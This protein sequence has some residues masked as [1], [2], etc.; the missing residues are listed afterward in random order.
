[1]PRVWP[2]PPR[3]LKAAVT[4]PWPL[5]SSAPPVIRP[6]VSGWAE[7][8][9]ERGSLG[10]VDVQRRHDVHVGV[11]VRRST[12]DVV[13]DHA[14]GAARGHVGALGHARVHAALAGH[15]LA[16]EAVRGGRHLAEVV[17]VAGCGGGQD[18]RCLAGLVAGRGDA[19]ESE[20]GPRRPEGGAALEALVRRRCGRGGDPRLAVVDRVRAGTGIPAGGGHE[21]TGR[22]G[23]EE[24]EGD[25][26]RIRILPAADREVD[27][28][29]P[30]HDGLLDG[31]RGVRRIAAGAI[32]PVG[33][34]EADLVGREVRAGGH[35]GD[36]GA[37]RR[38]HAAVAGRGGGRVGAVPVVVTGG[39]ELVEE[40][41]ARSA[42]GVEGRH[43][44]RGPDQLVVAGER[45]VVRV[46]GS[47]AELAGGAVPLRGRR[48]VAVVLDGGVLRPDPGVDDPDDHALAG[49]RL[50]ARLLPQGGSA[51][52][53]GAA[54]GLHG[55][56]DVR[57]DRLH[58]GKGVQLLDLVGRQHDGDAADDLAEA[59]HEPRA[60]QAGAH[61]ALELAFLVGEE[62]LV[63]AGPRGVRFD[64]A[65]SR[66]L[67]AGRFETRHVAHVFRDGRSV[68]LDDHAD[69]TVDSFWQRL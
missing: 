64:A 59:V 52:E 63:G 33:E 43:E 57:I 51:D 41:A 50:S 54:V 34:G 26:V 38:R 56:E 39:L 13:Q 17:R 19:R 66:G 6:V 24:G 16:V 48:G 58:A 15:D 3:E 67:G 4:S 44:P 25:G 37:R 68:E 29:H 11:E 22:V 12:G 5:R 14:H 47:G 10:G 20:G 69:P 42:E 65:R 32:G 18:D 7:E 36:R 1:M 53:H 35:A 60:R 23:V 55:Q 31:G 45:G 2:G 46:A 49:M 9:D 61:R 21:H 62:R 27:D 28:V 30:V 8:G 40:D